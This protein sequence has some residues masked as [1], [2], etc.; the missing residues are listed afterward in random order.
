MSATPNPVT[1]VARACGQA[2]GVSIAEI[3]GPSR[4]AEIV[5]AR[6]M[7]MALAR[8]YLGWSQ[9]K[10]ARAFKR[11]DHTVAQHALKTWP[12]RAGRPHLAKALPLVRARID[13][14]LAARR[15][16]LATASP[17]A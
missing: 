2:L 16:A 3:L 11:A 5:E 4:R 1:I 15:A 12:R 17:Q 8:E 13:Q 10:I 9:P 7:A 6:H 14:E